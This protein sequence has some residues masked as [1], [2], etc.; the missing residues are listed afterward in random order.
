[1]KLS[2]LILIAMIFLSSNLHALTLTEE[3]QQ[4]IESANVFERGDIIELKKDKH[5]IACGTKDDLNKILD[6]VARHDVDKM[7]P[8]LNQDQCLTTDDRL[9]KFKVVDIDQKNWDLIKIVSVN[10]V[11]AQGMWTTTM[12]EFAK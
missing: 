5:F 6:Y 2:K 4:R 8:M 12:F 10:A 9:G 11:G 7:L 1:M 3:V